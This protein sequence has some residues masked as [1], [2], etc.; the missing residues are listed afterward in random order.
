MALVRQLTTAGLRLISKSTNVSYPG[1]QSI[2]TD[3]NINSLI[4]I[5][6]FILHFDKP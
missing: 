3:G 1:S 5:I 2:K 4:P 6:F